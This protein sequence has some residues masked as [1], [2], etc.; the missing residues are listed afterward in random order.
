[1]YV[2]ALA[3]ILALSIL[4]VPG[5]AKAKGDSTSDGKSAAASPASHVRWSGDGLRI[6]L[7]SLSN[8]LVRAFF[9]GRGFPR[10]HTEFLAQEACVFRSDIGHASKTTAG[11]PHQPVTIELKK[12]TVTAGGKTHPLRTREAWKAVWEKRGINPSALV[13]FHWALIPTEQTYLPTDYNWG[14][15]TFGEK[16][17]T[18]FDLKIAWRQGDEPRTHIFTGLICGK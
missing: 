16:P 15:L 11:K 14:M 8:D 10:E 18:K 5:I 17:G 2:A 9:I 6:E 12:W 7:Q 1:M 4:S 3:L 13:A